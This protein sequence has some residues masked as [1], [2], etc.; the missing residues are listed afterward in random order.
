MHKALY[1]YEYVFGFNVII[2]NT[3][4]MEKRILYTIA[5][6]L[7]SLCASA[8]NSIGVNTDTPNAN[9]ALDIQPAAGQVQGV[10]IPRLTTVER[11]GMTLTNADNGMMAFDSDL[12][13]LFIWHNGTWLPMAIDG[14]DLWQD[15]G[16]D[17]HYSGGNVGIGTTTPSAQLHVYNNGVDQP[18]VVT[19]DAQGTQAGQLSGLVIQTLGD[20]TTD[21]SQGATNGWMMLGYGDSFS[22]VLRQNELTFSNFLGGVETSAIL[23]LEPNGKV[24][25][26]TGDPLVSLDIDSNDAIKIP[27]GTAAEA[28]TGAGATDGMLRYNTDNSKFEGYSAGSWSGLG[29]S[30]WAENAGDINYSGGLVGIG[31]VTPRSPLQVEQSL[32]LFNFENST[33]T[34][35]GNF[36]GSDLYVD[37]TNAADNEIKRISG[38]TGSFMFFEDGGEIKFLHTTAGAADATVA[39]TT[40]AQSSL[41]LLPDGS[42]EF[43]GIVNFKSEEAILLPVGGN[44]ERDNISS[45]I[46]GMIRYSNESGFEGFEGRI[47][48]SWIP[49]GGSGSGLTLPY[50]DAFPSNAV[51]LFEIVNTDG[52]SGIAASFGNTSNT[53]AALQVFTDLGGPGITGVTG[54]IEL[55]GFDDGGV[56]QSISQIR[57][58]LIDGM[59]GSF[60]GN[61]EFDVSNGAVL[62]HALTLKHD[63]DA[64]FPGAVKI[65]DTANTLTSGDEGTLRYVLATGFQYWNGGSWTPLTAGSLTGATNGLNVNGSN[66]ELGGSLTTNTEIS[67]N[68]NEFTIKRGSPSNAPT[69]HVYN[70]NGGVNTGGSI[71]LEGL[72]SAT[73][74]VVLGNIETRMTST[75]SGVE[76]AEMVMSVVTSGSLTEALKIDDLGE[77]NANAYKY[78]SPITKY[79]GISPVDFSLIK[80]AAAGDNELIANNGN[81]VAV[82]SATEQSGAQIAAPVH[83]PDGAEI[84]SVEVMGR[85]T[86]GIPTTLHFVAKSYSTAVNFDDTGTI[87]VATG[88]I[89]GFNI[90]LG[91]TRIIDNNNNNYFIYIDLPTTASPNLADISGARITYTITSAN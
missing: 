56:L 55:A 34:I 9:A 82:T 4:A 85:N 66:A 36:V 21:V 7:L 49:L 87:P 15:N 88:A 12:G 70:D 39:L 89:A 67:V 84:T 53:D 54:G 46:D 65:G 8:Q 11:T 52:G 45:P 1:F 80:R 60:S 91:A 81:S 28:P 27:K 22:D 24:G 26:G 40:E 77:V 59:A 47:L 32:S 5:I 83:L 10:L 62:N 61:L 75:T 50:S 17:I 3:S 20:G 74:P 25:I 42:A 72:N 86:T 69:L 90:T 57:S 2:F 31:T 58:N 6:S 38:S 71:V 37:K 16:G 68:G 33:N 30:L 64:V 23:H 18:T 19:I 76:S 44:L 35:F 29:G 79:Y 41:S 14:G 78:N 63:G 73:N 13:N 43:D 51:P 48:G